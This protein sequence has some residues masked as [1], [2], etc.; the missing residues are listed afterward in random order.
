MTAREPHI[1]DKATPLYR[2][3]MLELERRRQQLGVPMWQLDDLGGTQDGYFGKALHADRPSGRQ[4]RWETLHLIISA[5]FPG[6]FDVLIKPKPGELLT[7][8]VQRLKVKYAAADHCPRARRD[9]MRELGRRGGIARRERLKA[10]PA[11]QRKRIAKKAAKTRRKNRALRQQLRGFAQN[12][13][14]RL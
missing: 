13:E 12:S 5:L 7:P 10:M 9:L 2:A 11:E 6:G 3:I 8:E 1:V 4:A 14:A